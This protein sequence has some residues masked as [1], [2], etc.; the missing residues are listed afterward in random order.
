MLVIKSKR[1]KFFKKVVVVNMCK[2]FTEVKTFTIEKI[3]FIIMSQRM[4]YLGIKLTKKVK[5][6]YTENCKTMMKKI[7]G[8]INK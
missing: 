7:I 8:Y 2:D 6:F 4:K 1:F 5:D 3:L